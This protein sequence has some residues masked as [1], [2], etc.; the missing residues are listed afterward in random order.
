MSLP[1]NLDLGTDQYL[2]GVVSVSGEVGGNSPKKSLIVR[3]LSTHDIQ[4]DLF[5]R[6]DMTY[7]TSY[8]NSAFI[9]SVFT[10]LTVFEC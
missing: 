5:R 1:L 10:K 3:T 6:R 9:Y 2:R 8:S 4:T 7:K